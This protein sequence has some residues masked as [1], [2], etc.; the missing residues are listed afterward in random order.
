MLV[1]PLLLVRVPLPRLGAQF[2][3]YRTL[4]S[5]TCRSEGVEHRPE[6]LGGVGE[7]D[8]PIPARVVGVGL[9]RVVILAS[10]VPLARD[11][12]T[13]K[14]MGCERCTRIVPPSAKRFL[15]STSVCVWLAE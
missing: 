15:A 1:E 4:H 10:E 11:R 9:S 6:G 2:W 14:R 5:E 3:L 13:A 7:R 12:S 8:S